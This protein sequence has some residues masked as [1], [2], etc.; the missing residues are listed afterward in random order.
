VLVGKGPVRG[1]AS[2]RAPLERC[3]GGAMTEIWVESPGVWGEA[4]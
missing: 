2:Q 1:K 3:S 4:P